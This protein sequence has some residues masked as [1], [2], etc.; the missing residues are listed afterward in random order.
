MIISV[1]IKNVKSWF[2]FMI[3][4]LICLSIKKLEPIGAKLFIFGRKLKASIDYVTQSYYDVQ[5]LFC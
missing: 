3:R 5:K 1:L 4:L 2:C